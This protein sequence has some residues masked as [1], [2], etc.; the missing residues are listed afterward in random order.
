MI[1]LRSVEEAYSG[2]LY[3]ATSLRNTRSI[4]MKDRF[5]LKPSEGSAS[6]ERLSAG[7]NYMSCARTPGGS[8]YIRNRASLNNMILVLDGNALS[9]RYSMRPVDYWANSTDKSVEGVRTINETEERVLSKKPFIPNATRYIVSV[10]GSYTAGKYNDYEYEYFQI[11]KHC[12]MHRIPVYWYADGADMWRMR[13][14][15]RVHPQFSVGEQP[16]IKLTKYAVEYNLRNNDINPWLELWYKPYPTSVP[17]RLIRKKYLT[18]KAGDRLDALSYSDV[19]YHLSN[20]MH[21]AK[22]TSYDSVTH[23]REALDHLVQIMR[24]NRMNRDQFIEALRK[25]W[26]IQVRG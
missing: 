18:K 12:L 15:D 19:S 8:T 10:H 20:D 26:H 4:L 7:Y 24:T 1:I 23:E 25:K 14:Q 13:P 21:N 2:L 22:G 11:E 5:E 16:R 17:D 9:T 3:H 6:E